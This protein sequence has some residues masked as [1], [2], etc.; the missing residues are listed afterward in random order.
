MM[1]EH[2]AHH[3]NEAG[4]DDE[5]F[6]LLGEAKEKLQRAEV[7]RAATNDKKPPTEK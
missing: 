4:R 6:A 7:F 3:A 2:L 5:A 1:R